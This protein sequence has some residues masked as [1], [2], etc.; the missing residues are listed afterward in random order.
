MDKYVETLLHVHEFVADL[1]LNAF[2]I[3]SE[4]EGAG[5]ETLMMHEEG[6]KEYYSVLFGCE[7]ARN[8]REGRPELQTPLEDFMYGLQMVAVFADAATPARVV[9]CMVDEQGEYFVAE[10]GETSHFVF[11]DDY[12]SIPTHLHSKRSWPYAVKVEGKTD[13]VRRRTIET[14]RFDTTKKGI[15]VIDWSYDS[16]VF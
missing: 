2:K 5:R 3:E 14:M 7:M 4:I 15:K 8:I 12:I 11:E 9:D 13:L 1:V 16:T 6:T 10:F